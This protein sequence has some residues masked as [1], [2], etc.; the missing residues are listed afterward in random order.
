MTEYDYNPDISEP[1]YPAQDRV[2]DWAGSA[3]HHGSQFSAFGA[4]EPYDDYTNHTHRTRSHRG[5]SQTRRDRYNNS[6]YSSDGIHRDNSRHTLQSGFTNSARSG[7]VHP[8]QFYN[9]SQNPTITSMRGG[10]P[11]TVSR[12]HSM[13]N[14]MNQGIPGEPSISSLS[15]LNA[16]VPDQFSY[17]GS[18]N[19]AFQHT[20]PIDIPYASSR[21][22]HRSYSRPFE[23]YPS[24][25][26]QPPIVVPPSDRSRHYSR[27]RRS[28]SDYSY[29]TDS[30]SY[31]SRSRSRSY[32]RSRSRSPYRYSHG[33]RTVHTSRNSPTI[34]HPSRDQPTVVP[35]NGGS[36]GYVV[37]PA[38]GQRLK[39]ANTKQYRLAG[40]P[41]FLERL[42]S[43][44]KWG[45]KY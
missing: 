38:V 5:R 35:I 22:S 2:T 37:V 17:S 34:I 9:A 26:A 20:Q 25:Y 36:G 40:E 15:I 13:R 43:P 14:A 24:S 44:S 32:S 23:G 41:S 4:R 33:Y 3:Q 39:V 21:R 11:G 10:I 18:Q 29:S 27:S 31:S 30:G 8:T 16:P 12:T 7:Q 6:S 1:Y 45:R 42:L 28:H 19:N